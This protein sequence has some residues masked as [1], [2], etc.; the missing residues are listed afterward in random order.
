MER[1]GTAPW[2]IIGRLLAWFRRLTTVSI[3][4]YFF[5]HSWWPLGYS[6]QTIYVSS[7]ILSDI[8]PCTIILS[9]PAI[10]RNVV[11]HKGNYYEF[12][13][14]SFR[15]GRLEWELQMVQLSATG[16]SCILILS[17]SLVSFSTITFLL[18][19]NECFVVVVV[20]VY[21]VIGS[22]RKLLDILSYASKF[23]KLISYADIKLLSSP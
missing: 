14:K 15:T 10:C 2:I 8:Q 9:V 16:C 5:S 18:L 7:K 21:V 1:V 12:V 3:F 20:V 4:N 17:V 23:Y 13:S 19:F 6:K 22:V 11:Q